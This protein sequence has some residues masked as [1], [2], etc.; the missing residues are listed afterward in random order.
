MTQ[1]RCLLIG[2]LG[3]SPTADQPFG[4][5]ELS[6]NR[7]R[8]CYFIEPVASDTGLA[9]TLEKLV[10]ADRAPRYRVVLDGRRSSCDCPGCCQRGT[11]KHLIAL[12]LLHQ[13]GQL[14][15]RTLTSKKENE[16]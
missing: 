9:F 8:C 11:C 16:P 15:V 7:E 6:T 4:L 2:W 14:P 5:L 13:R 1:P 3:P 10:K 12:R